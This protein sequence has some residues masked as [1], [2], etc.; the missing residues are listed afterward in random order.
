MLRID[1]DGVV[2]KVRIIVEL[3]KRS[4]LINEVLQTYVREKH[5]NGLQLILD[6]KTRWS[7]LLNM[8]ERILK[9]SVPVKESLLDLNIEIKLTD[10]EFTKVSFVV[11]ALQ[12][13]KIAVEALCWRDANFISAE[14]TIKILPDEIKNYLP[15]GSEYIHQITEAI[16]VNR[17]G[18]LKFA[19]ID[20][21]FFWFGD[22]A[23][24][25]GVHLGLIF[26]QTV[27]KRTNI[28]PVVKAMDSNY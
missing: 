14:A 20:A 13:F 24:I 9:I 16:F 2:N 23:R 5:P 4:P 15:S 6:C 27:P 18:G 22:M 3:F 17:T 1:I 8:L 21:D 26:W 12:P 28:A 11:Q 10:E 25:R 19:T 7:S